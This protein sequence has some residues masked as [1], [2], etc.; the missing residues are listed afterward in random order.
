MTEINYD[1]IDWKMVPYIKEL[2]ALG[3]HTKFCCSGHVAT[4]MGQKQ[5]CLIRG[6]RIQYPKKT[7]RNVVNGADFVSWPYL[8]CGRDTVFEEIC[9]NLRE[10][11]RKFHDCI[12]LSDPKLFSFSESEKHKW[13]I[14]F[15]IN[16]RHRTFDTQEIFFFFLRAAMMKYRL[17]K[18]K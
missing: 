2:N 10:V 9:A 15:A 4:T 7:W 1:E 12:E 3:I 13:T 14:H 18:N 17:H 5:R 6:A 11:N 8:V 16:S